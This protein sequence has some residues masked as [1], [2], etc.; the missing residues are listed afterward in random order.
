[1]IFDFSC[2][3]RKNLSYNFELPKW[4]LAGSFT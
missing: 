1:M 2:V 4:F 3:R